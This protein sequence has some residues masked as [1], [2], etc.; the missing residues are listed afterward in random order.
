M[1]TIKDIKSF[2]QHH[3]VSI[4]AMSFHRCIL[5]ST[6]FRGRTKSYFVLFLTLN[7]S[8]TIRNGVL[9]SGYVK[10]VPTTV[11]SN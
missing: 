2:G 10:F 7:K 6:K 5:N 1:V 8:T 11:S 9:I 4:N 3:V